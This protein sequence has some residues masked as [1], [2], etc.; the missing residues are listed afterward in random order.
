MR[1]L[2]LA[3]RLSVMG[4]ADHH[5]RDVLA[6]QALRHRVT[7]AYGRVD[8]A[9]RVPAGVRGA[10]LRGL[11]SATE[12]EKGL[13]ELDGLLASA[14]VVHLHNVM[15]PVAI[16]RAVATGH[17]LATIQD[18]RV[19]CP[20]SGK[21]LPDGSACRAPMGEVCAVCL[22]DPEYRERM[23]GLTGARQRALSGA[24]LIALSRYM[25]GAI[26]AAG[27]GDSVVIPP[28]I[29]V[30]PRPS[31][32]GMGFALAGRMVAHKAPGLAWAAWRRSG[33]RHPLRVAGA[34]AQLAELPGVEAL[35]WLGR[36]QWRTA[37]RECRALLCPSLWQEP[38]GIVGVEALA[39]GTPVIAVVRGGMADWADAGCLQ[40]EP[41]AEAMAE[42]IRALER[43]PALAERLGAAGWSRVRERLSREVLA[44]RLE[45][46]VREVAAG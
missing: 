34:G 15:N 3:D 14:D 19:F 27:M 31:R 20:G 1:I 11:A 25:A 2:H 21:T 43:D 7:L 41:T 37:A 40:V 35:G 24:R 12:T 6:E 44:P 4:G 22:P 13:D 8:G 30:A 26:A 38:F 32:A 36:A 39:E 23:R 18:H 29:E 16:A 46:L 33:S 17:A 10:R 45:A 28:W 42:G 5:L 9:A